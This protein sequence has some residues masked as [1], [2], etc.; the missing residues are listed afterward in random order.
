MEHVCHHDCI[1]VSVLHS[2]SPSANKCWFSVA[3]IW[4]W[5]TECWLE[6]GLPS[7]R[8]GGA[9]WWQLRSVKPSLTAEET[10]VHYGICTLREGNY[11]AE[12][13]KVLLHQ[14]CL[15]TIMRSGFKKIREL[16]LNQHPDQRQQQ[17]TGAGLNPRPARVSPVSGVL[18]CN[19]PWPLTPSGGAGRGIWVSRWYKR[20]RRIIW[21]ACHFSS[22][23]LVLT[24]LHSA[25]SRG[26]AEGQTTN[27]SE[28]LTPS[29]ISSSA[30]L[31]IDFFLNL[32]F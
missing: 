4:N 25:R 23:G 7:L 21:T 27:R 30:F 1:C 2:K 29:Y 12:T 8:A 20:T 14:E 18:F 22:A 6:S 10:V 17:C 26:A 3:I 5:L 15:C 9:F 16:W 32:F 19:R 13:G 24:R 28:V 31:V 11:R